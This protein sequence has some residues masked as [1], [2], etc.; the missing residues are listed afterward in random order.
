[1]RTSRHQVGKKKKRN[2]QGAAKTGGVREERTN[3]NNREGEG[4]EEER[5]RNLVANSTKRNAAFRSKSGT[6]RHQNLRRV[7]TPLS[8]PRIETHQRRRESVLH[9]L[10]LTRSGA[11][12]FFFFLKLQSQQHHSPATKEGGGGVDERQ[13]QKTQNGRKKKKHEEDG[14]CV[15]FAHKYRKGNDPG[16]GKVLGN[17]GFSK[18]NERST[19]E[20]TMIECAPLLALT[21]RP[22]LPT[23]SC[24]QQPAR[25]ARSLM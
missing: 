5:K 23:H 21:K 12:V 1:M 7:L 10:L 3:K 20:K 18:Q 13:K 6:V 24:T 19:R 22:R 17:S 2:W 15:P 9:C 16:V 8:L 25:C 4:E 11:R 14:D